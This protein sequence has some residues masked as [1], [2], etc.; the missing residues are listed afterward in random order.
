MSQ[1]YQ[2]TCSLAHD[3]PMPGTTPI[4]PIWIHTENVNV[5]MEL[6]SLRLIY[7][8]LLDTVNVDNIVRA[9]ELIGGHV[10]R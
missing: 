8:T 10:I 6:D 7:N 4:W 9:R 5:N 2:T 1:Q 3:V